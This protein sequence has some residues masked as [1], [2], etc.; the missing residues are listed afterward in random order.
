MVDSWLKVYPHPWRSA[1]ASN[2]RTCLLTRAV[3]VTLSARLP[4]ARPEELCGTIQFVKEV[5]GLLVDGPRHPEAFRLLLEE[6]APELLHRLARFFCEYGVHWASCCLSGRLLEE[7]LDLLAEFV[8]PRRSQDGEPEG[9]AQLTVVVGDAAG[10][11]QPAHAL[12]LGGPR[13]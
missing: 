5:L 9:P 3:R 7:G 2:R 4:H 11:E 6:Q 13:F 12:I 1:N 10:S 8:H